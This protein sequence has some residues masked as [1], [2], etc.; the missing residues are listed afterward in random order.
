MLTFWTSTSILKQNGMRLLEAAFH[1]T[2]EYSCLSKKSITLSF[3]THVINTQ[4]QILVQ[5]EFVE[6]GSTSGFYTLYLCRLY[7]VHFVDHG[8]L[9]PI[10]P[11][12]RE[13]HL[14]VP[15]ICIV[16]TLERCILACSTCKMGTFLSDSWWSGKS[17][18][19]WFLLLLLSECVGSFNSHF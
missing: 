12:L 7:L 8:H 3:L 16:L 9:L 4:G 15:T 1:F 5:C 10:L 2:L 19:W 13:S 18:S 6:A 14:T 11:C 17:A